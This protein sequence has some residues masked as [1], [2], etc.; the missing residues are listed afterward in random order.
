MLSATISTA[1]IACGTTAVP[2]CPTLKLTV[3][4]R[5]RAEDPLKPVLP[6]PL[7]PISTPEAQAERTYLWGA[8]V[9]PLMDFSLAQ[10]VARWAEAQRADG[11][12]AKVDAH[13][14]AIAPKKWRWPWSRDPSP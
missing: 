9:K 8:V 13:N 7:A 6:R 14:A 2:A 10:E 11:V 12:V 3:G 1:L 5:T 4:D